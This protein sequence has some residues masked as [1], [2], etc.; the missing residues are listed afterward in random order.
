M[1]DDLKPRVAK[2]DTNVGSA[3]AAVSEA[4]AKELNRVGTIL[5]YGQMI[6]FFILLVIAF[7][8]QSTLREHG[9]WGLTL[10]GLYAT[11]LPTAIFG[12][13][14]GLHKYGVRIR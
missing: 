11:G 4:R 2:P 5:L 7:L 6:I 12:L 3:S 14:W 1:R 9:M 8:F 13:I 10:F